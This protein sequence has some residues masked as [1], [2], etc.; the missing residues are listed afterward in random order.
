[1]KIVPMMTPATYADTV[2]AIDAMPMSYGLKRISCPQK[3]IKVSKMKADTKKPIICVEVG[4]IAKTIIA[5]T[6]PTAEGIPILP[7]THVTSI[8]VK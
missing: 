1:M 2:V 5:P 7:E 4:L 6:K 8:K 3:I